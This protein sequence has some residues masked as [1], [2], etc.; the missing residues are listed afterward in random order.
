MASL[1]ILM[2]RLGVQFSD[3]RLL[4]S[5]LVHRSFVHEHPE[6]TTDLANSERLEFLGDA[7]INYIAAALIFERFP[8]NGEGDMTVLRSA[9]IK[10]GT[11]AQFARRFDLG[12]SIK[13][14]KGDAASNGR[15]RD[16][17]LADTF[18]AIIAAITLDQGFDTAKAFVTPLFQEELARIE[19]QG[20]PL[21]Y[22]S[23]LQ[24][25]VQAQRNITPRYQTV[26]V[27]GPEHRRE[28][29]IEVFADEESLGTGQG[30]SKQSAAQ[31]AAKAALEQLGALQ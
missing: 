8:N 4:Q 6:L 27:S 30:F 23:R 17:L 7:V 22:K 10:T 28:F 31:A 11:L 29:L 20:L 2:Q 13:L 12:N 19:I 24:Q 26:S 1:D 15:D 5:A 25:F 18:E 14:S 9:L 21:D 16:S 3:P